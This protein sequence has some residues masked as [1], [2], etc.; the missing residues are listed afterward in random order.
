MLG[1]IDMGTDIAT[2]VKYV[3]LN[4]SIA[5]AQGG[6]LGFSLFVQSLSRRNYPFW[7]CPTCFG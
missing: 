6:I 3:T 1:Y 7:R 4:P 5:I 2:M